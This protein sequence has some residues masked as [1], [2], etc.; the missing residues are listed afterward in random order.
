LGVSGRESEIIE[1]ALSHGFKGIDLE[2]VE[3]AEQARTQGQAKAA[4]LL[5]S[6]RLKLASFVLPVRWQRNSPD[7]QAD[8]AALAELAP[9]ARELG[10]TRAVT[11]IE[12]D[13]DERVYH[14]NFEFHRKRL[15]EIG[16]KLAEHG[17]KLGV[18][19]LAPAACRQDR[20]YQFMQKADEVL[21]LL[22]TVT[23]KNVGLA[24]DTFHWQLGG[25]SVEQVRSLGAERIITVALGDVEPARTAADAQPSDRR[26][27]A[28]EGAVDNVGI[29]AALAELNYDGP[30]TPTADKSQLGA[31][32]R[33]Q[34]VKAAAAACDAVW[35]AA[36]LSPA[37]KRATVSGR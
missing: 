4:R 6:S 22:G 12:P 23:A 17:I 28:E 16:G 33:D 11:T 10:C 30:V 13:S 26:L 5:A 35:K 7:Y 19:F 24:L 9:L 36:G 21:M 18:G 27:P 37:G 32:S 34:T 8:L 20:A 3:F 2:L 1:L 31:A 29:L 15:A 25:G 14:E